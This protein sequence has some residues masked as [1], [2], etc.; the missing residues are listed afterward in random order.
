MS[1]TF[2]YQEDNV[3]GFLGR[4]VI[5]AIALFVISYFNWGLKIDNLTTTLIAA[6][7]LGV[8]NAIV[9][10]VLQILSLPITILTLGLFALVINALMFWLVGQLVPGVQE[11][12]WVLAWLAYSLIT[13]IISALIR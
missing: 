1:D 3:D 9:R 4:V 12:N 6:L 10:P 2:S 11:S 7:V 13:W 8:L 5:N